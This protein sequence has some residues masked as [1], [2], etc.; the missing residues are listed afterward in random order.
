[1]TERRELIERHVSENPGIGFNELKRELELSNGVLQYHLRESDKIVKKKGT[2][3]PEGICTDCRFKS[4]CG[5]KCV[6][7]ATRKKKAQKIL[8]GKSDGVKQSEIGDKLDI[9]DS[10]VSYHVNKLR[11]VGLIDED[12]NL[13]VEAWKV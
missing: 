5:S 9:D 13:T 1:M 12:G 3:L 4:I 10:T 11:D 8:K 2:Y 6:L 7:N